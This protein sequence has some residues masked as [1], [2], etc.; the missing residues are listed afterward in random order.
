MRRLQAVARGNSLATSPLLRRCQQRTTIQVVTAEHIASALPIGQRIE[1]LLREMGKPPAWL[2]E[3]AGL[4]RSTVSRI[5]KGARN[6]T[7]ETLSNLAPVLGVSLEQLVAG[8]DAAARV[9]E[10]ANLVSRAH[11]EDAV[12]QLIEFERKAND[13]AEQLRVE[14]EVSKDAQAKRR[15]AEEAARTVQADRDA[16]VRESKR[17]EEDARRYQEALQRAVADVARLQTDVAELSKAVD[18]SRLT[19]RMAAI[20]AGTAALASVASYLKGR[21]PEP[22]PTRETNE[23]EQS[24][25]RKS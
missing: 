3:K 22:T 5:L 6:P 10:A 23:E 13:L 9:E 20:L 18:Q 19:G 4:E 12:R 21:S 7:P 16:A 15:D 25:R 8:T 1:E 14:K 24:T 17:H 2:A 11:Y